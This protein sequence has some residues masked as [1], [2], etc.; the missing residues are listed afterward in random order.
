[1]GKTNMAVSSSAQC[2]EA[3]AY[4]GQES[5]LGHTQMSLVRF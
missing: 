4:E 3:D 5:C 2:G 1:M